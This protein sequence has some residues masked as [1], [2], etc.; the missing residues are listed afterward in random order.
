MRHALQAKIDEVSISQYPGRKW[1]LVQHA[2]R[3]F[4]KHPCHTL[5]ES[6]AGSGIVGLSLLHAG[7]VNRLVL[8]EKDVRVVCMLRGLITQSDLAQK[9]AEFKCT[10]ANVE[11]LFRGKK[12]AFHYLVQS[13]VCNRGRFTGGMRSQI[14]ARW[15]KELV[16]TNLRRVYEMRN[17]ITVIDGDGLDVM[18]DHLADRNIGCFCDPPYGADSTSKG[19]FLYPHHKIDHKKLFSLLEDWRGPWL[20][21]EDNCQMVRRLALC[22]RFAV[23]RMRM[24]TSDSIIKHELMIWRKRN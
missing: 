12:N 4:R 14:D 19:R 13:R 21:T 3:F 9:Y 15:C 24:N 8:V 22:H 11:E 7:I 5:V 6:F 23:K 1:W 2:A 18:R 10:R 20:L 17:R 16:V